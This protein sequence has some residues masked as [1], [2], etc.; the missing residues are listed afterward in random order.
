MRLDRSEWI[1]ASDIDVPVFY[2]DFSAEDIERASLAVT[3]CGIYEV[4]VN[5]QRISEDLL[6]PGWTNY[7]K[8]IQYQ[9]YDITPFIRKE[10]RI[11]ITAAPGWWAGYLNGEGK[12]HH[13]GDRVA[14]RA[15]LTMTAADGSEAV[16][17]TGADWRVGSSPVRSAELYHGEVIDRT[18]SLTDLCAAESYTLPYPAELSA[19]MPVGETVFRRILD[20]MNE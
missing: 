1:T 7:R 2:R 4:T 6:R 10:N 17:G 18:R 5:G 13:Y 16:I 11:E 20:R 15:A 12:N 14:V 3:A 9:E 8:R 19:M